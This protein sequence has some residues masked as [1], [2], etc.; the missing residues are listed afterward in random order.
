[1][2]VTECFIGDLFSDV[3][4]ESVVSQVAVMEVDSAEVWHLLIVQA[5]VDEFNA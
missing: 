5:F 2:L 1:M 3:V 4:N